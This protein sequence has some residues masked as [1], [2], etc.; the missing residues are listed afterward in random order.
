MLRNFLIY[1]SKANWMK[2]IMLK[3][4]IARKVALRFVAGEKLEDAILVAKKLNEKGMN[5]TLDQLGEDTYTPEEARETGDQI[6]EIL[7]A[8]ERSGVTAGVSLKLT[9]IGL[10]LGE[11]LCVEILADL[12]SLA[13]RYNN[14]IRIDIEDSA[15]VDATMRVYKRIQDEHGLNNVGMVLQSYL[16]RSES[17]LIELLKTNT[18]IRM[19]KGA[20]TELPAIAYQKK[21]EV[22]ENFDSLMEIMLDTTL[23][24]NEP[25]SRKNGKFPPLAAAGTHDPVRVEFIKEYARLI[26]LPKEKFEIQMLYGIN[27]GLQ[28]SLASEGYPVRIYIP[29]GAEWYPYFMRRLAERPANLWFFLT[30]LFRG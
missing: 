2:E 26:G 1:L 24:N 9:Q 12:A 11:D 25:A 4:G 30:A 8:I 19:V 7:I 15:R 18:K 27:K 16:Y 29:F 5:A 20:Y 28:D 10:D 3:W 6:K 21:K 23:K 13:K 22:D 14:F 17:D